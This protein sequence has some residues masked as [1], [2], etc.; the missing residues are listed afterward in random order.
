ME[1]RCPATLL[2]WCLVGHQLD[3]VWQR[4]QLRQSI[5]SS[6][7]LAGHPR[8]CWSLSI[9]PSVVDFSAQLRFYFCAKTKD[10]YSEVCILQWHLQSFTAD[11]GCQIYLLLTWQ[12][13][14]GIGCR[15]TL[16]LLYAYW[17]C[18][19]TVFFRNEVS[20]SALLASYVKW[21]SG[22]IRKTGQLL[23]SRWCLSPVMWC[24]CDIMILY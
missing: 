12:G 16:L 19:V 24:R 9:I 2:H 21:S 4:W 23:L 11:T 6:G 8:R 14:G 17:S 18:S 3:T 1:H 20:F 10:N 15:W 7:H 13:Q 5:M 22:N